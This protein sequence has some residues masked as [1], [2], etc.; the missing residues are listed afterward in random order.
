MGTFTNLKNNNKLLTLNSKV[1][2]IKV[3]AIKSSQNAGFGI[4]FVAALIDV[5][6]VW[7]GTFVVQAVFKSMRMPG[8]GTL[9]SIL[10][11]WAYY[12]YFIGS[13]GQTLGKKAMNLKVVNLDTGKNPD[14]VGAFL[15]EIVGKFISSLVLLLGYLW[16]IWDNKKQGWHDKIANTVVVKTK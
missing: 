4:R 11:A 16:V 7:I 14:Y 15:R 5:V 6:I 9:V 2:L 3:M 10:G 8:L 13:T 12:I 1:A